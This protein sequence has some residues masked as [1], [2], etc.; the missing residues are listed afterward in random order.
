MMPLPQTEPCIQ[1][2]EQPKAGK[3]SDIPMTDAAGSL[4]P[5]GDEKAT[6]TTLA[7][8]PAARWS[9]RFLNVWQ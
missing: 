5:A 6:I 2:E 7:D 8:M 9:G 3:H 1:R 4:R